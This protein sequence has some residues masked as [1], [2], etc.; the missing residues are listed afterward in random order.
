MLAT[1]TF[2]AVVSRTSAQAIALAYALGA[3]HLLVLPLALEWLGAPRVLACLS[4][5][6]GFT[7]SISLRGYGATGRLEV[8]PVRLAATFLAGLA[9][10]G[11]EY[12]LAHRIFEK[13]W[14][15]DR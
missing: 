13:R 9:A 6:G 1:E 2:S 3:G 14:M 5:I 7:A 15:R 4:P 10:A 11:L 8:L 12:F